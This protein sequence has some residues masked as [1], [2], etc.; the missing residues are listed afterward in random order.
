MKRK[1][2]VI[3]A[4]SITLLW[5]PPQ[6]WSQ[7]P[8]PL[9]HF[10]YIGAITDSDLD[11]V[12]SYTDFTYVDGEYG[13]S[14]VNLVT[15]IKSKGMRAV[16]DLGRVLWC[17]QDPADPFGPWHLC[18]TAELSY[19]T[20]WNQWVSMNSS[21][22]NDAHVLAF[23]VIAEPS[24]RGISTIDVETAVELVKLTRPQ[25]P[26]LVAESFVSMDPSTFQ[27][28]RNA[29]WVGIAGYYMRPNLNGAFKESVRILKLKKQS[30]QRIAYTMDA[31]YGESHYA[32]A[33]TVAD[34]DTIAQ[35]WYTIASRDPEAILLAPFL[36]ANLSGE[37]AIGSVSFPQNVLNKHAAIGAAILAGKAP[38]YQ[39]YFDRI[40]CQ[41]ISGWAWD[42]SQPNTPVSVDI[43]DGVEKITTVR[44]NQFRQDLLNANIGNGQ[45]GFSFNTPPRLRDGQSHSVV[46]K[47][48]GLD[49]QLSLSPRSIN[50]PSAPYVG[51]VD[52]ADCNSIT[53]WAADRNRPNTS[54]V[55][56]IFDGTTFVTSVLASDF[57]SDVGALLGDNG[58]HGFAI[59]TPAHFKDGSQHTLR[60]KFEWTPTE[61]SSSPRTITCA[62]QTTYYE[63]EILQI[64]MDQQNDRK[65]AAGRRPSTN[66]G[67]LHAAAFSIAIN[68]SLKIRSRRAGALINGIKELPGTP[69]LRE[70]QSI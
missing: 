20:R 55:V 50:C 23:S 46:I 58:R 9:K 11:R 51:W 4:I 6:S 42:A 65:C 41:S 59:A 37:G 16:I 49:Q 8:Q 40:D 1:L 44:A 17:P 3:L 60:V 15:R 26:T 10:G 21:V 34:M 67:S 2:A 18:S 68:G 27:V 14:I 30:W 43:Y 22:L 32:I 64:D 38:T 54:I 12:R 69:P 48:S 53:G 70:A 7:S 57:R 24:L 39:G 29:D 25:I 36:W 35:E 45:H 47:Y 5:P 19:N 63:I 62:P 33:P 66:Q 31:F 61:L 52:V 56:S 28:P 13:Q